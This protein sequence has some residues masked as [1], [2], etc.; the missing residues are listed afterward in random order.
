MRAHTDIAQHGWRQS[1]VAKCRLQTT[2]GGWSLHTHAI[3]RHRVDCGGKRSCDRVSAP[4]A[5]RRS[6]CKRAPTIASRRVV[7][8][9]AH[10]PFLIGALR[11]QSSIFACRRRLL[12]LRSLS[13]Q[14]FSALAWFWFLFCWCFLCLVSLI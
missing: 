13:F 10:A 5:L 9:L 12:V 1:A 8:A 14:I 2:S 11:F 7:R 3:A 4:T 6:D